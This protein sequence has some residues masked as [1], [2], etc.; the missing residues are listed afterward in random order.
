MATTIEFDITLGGTDYDLEVEIDASACWAWSP[1]PNHRPPE[2]VVT[3]TGAC[4]RGLCVDDLA[5][6]WKQYEAAITE[7]ALEIFTDRGVAAYENQQERAYE[8]RRYG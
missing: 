5:P 8:R 1:D 7:R 2:P 4:A 3:L 6:I